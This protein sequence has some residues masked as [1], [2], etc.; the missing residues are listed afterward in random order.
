MRYTRVLA[1]LL[2]ALLD[3]GCYNA[4]PWCTK[5]RP[6]S[7]SLASDSLRPARDTAERAGRAP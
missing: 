1:V 5:E 6:C 4:A 7:D 3:A 2:L